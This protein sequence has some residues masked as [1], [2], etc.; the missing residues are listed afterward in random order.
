MPAPPYRKY[1]VVLN[2]SERS[3]AARIQTT[4]AELFAASNFSFLYG[5]SHPEEYVQT[6]AELGLQALAVTDTNSVAGIV[7]AHAAAEELKIAY[8]V[9]CRLE[10]LCAAETEKNEH[11]H[12]S[13]LYFPFNKSAYASLCHTL[14]N[15]NMRAQKGQ[16]PVCLE[17]LNKLSKDAAFILVPPFLVH[18]TPQEIQSANSHFRKLS[19]EL[20]QINPALLLMAIARNY[21]HDQIRQE[22]LIKE[23]ATHL[24]IPL[25]ATNAA[26]FHAPARKHLCDVLTCIKHH[27][28]I[29]QAG[30]LLQANS[31]AYIKSPQEMAYLF[32]DMPDCL[33]RSIEVADACKHFSLTQLRY[34]YPNEICP[35]GLTPLAYLEALTWAGAKERYGLH[36]PDRIL[37][38]LREEL[39]LIHELAYEKY[40][41]TCYDIVR[42][43]RSKNILCQ[44]RGAAA[45][46]AVCYCLGITSVDPLT[47]DLLFSRFISRARNE[48]PD[49]D[50]D[51]EHERR[52][53][54]IQYI[55]E[56]YGRSH[57]ALTAEVVSYRQRSAVRETAKA[58]GLSLEIADSLAK[59]IHRWTGCSLP[60]S[61]LRA[62]GLDPHNKRLQDTLALSQELL[63]FPRHL[64]QHVGGFII[65]ETPLSDLV[66][67]LPASMENRSIIEW[68]K[69]DIEVL[70]MLKIDVLALGMLSCVRKSLDYIN[71]ER[72]ADNLPSLALHSIPQES[73]EVYD[74]ICQA[75]TVGVFQIESRA[76]MSMLPRLRPRCFYDLV[77]EVAI[78]RP[79]PIQG[80]MVHPFLKRRA[81]LEVV[82][83]PDERVKEILG[84]TLG[85][86]IFQE[87]A[88][89]L[90]IVL[91]NFSPDEAEGLRRA[92]ASW[93]KDKGRLVSFYERIMQGMLKNGFDREFAETCFSQMKGFSEYGFPESHAASFALIVYASAWIKRFHPAAFAAGL[94][95]SQPMGFYAPAQIIADARMHGVNIQA[96][97]V[98]ESL[99]DCVSQQNSLRLGFRLIYGLPQSQINIL[100]QF[101]SQQRSEIES[102]WTQT[103][104]LGLRKKTLILLAKANAFHFL[105]SSR[106]VLWRIAALPD[107]ILPLDTHLLRS[108]QEA[109]PALPLMSSQQSMF[110]DYQMTGLSLNAHPI[111]FVRAEL[112]TRGA[113]TA[114]Q[115]RQK[116]Q[117][118]TGSLVGVAG[119]VLVRQRPGTAKGVVFLTLEDETGMSNLIIRPPVFEQYQKPIIMHKSLY[120]R[121]IL[122][123]A[124]AVVYINVHSVESLDDLVFRAQEIPVAVKSYSY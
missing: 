41:L 110:Q 22:A 48:P 115:L 122:E 82:K 24:A 45:N 42:F 79:G 81:G 87:Q 59:S 120:V 39:S 35:E 29:D 3:P 123:R 51:F 95:N 106:Q 62:L 85:V 25:V 105:G 102:L 20:T 7:R 64:S 66:P 70:G 101:S 56:K 94:L 113:V 104:P 116:Q 99:W 61:E 10:V 63:S 119:L 52:E 121:G 5:A 111:G 84:K 50:I 100:L 71:S 23:L 2:S 75:D 108:Q 16:S 97:D 80:N 78:V 47:I 44:G 1:K 98:R 57:A 11:K 77:I 58:M 90:A 60:A 30:F 17:D 18:N 72:S 89:R 33:S 19:Q 46:S 55:Y 31:Q 118:R 88:M 4:Y 26:R 40:F 92:M 114:A 73:T 9:G 86:P 14:S 109:P 38:L 37:K 21:V 107:E 96:I 67:I 54:V 68:D 8:R 117:V 83:Y 6:A 12:C 32:R 53:E 91:A 49:I 69:D 65:S 34:S 43:A 36:I 13:I 76:Q 103:A 15:A 74:M 124:G 93:K 112:K 27:T 28:H